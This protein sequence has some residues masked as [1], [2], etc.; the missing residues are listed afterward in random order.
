MLTQPKDQSSNRTTPSD[1]QGKKSRQ[2]KLEKYQPSMESIQPKGLGKLKKI[3]MNSLCNLIG[4]QLF[5][6]N[7]RDSL[8]KHL[9]RL[10]SMNLL[11][12]HLSLLSGPWRRSRN[13]RDMSCKLWIP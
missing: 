1:I 5:G 6:K 2:L 3:P 9:K 4:H 8:S 12:K 13:P 11:R 7:P 10:L